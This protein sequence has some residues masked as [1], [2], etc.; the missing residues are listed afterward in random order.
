MITFTD[1]YKRYT[2]QYEALSGLSFELSKGEMAFL[3]GHSG[4]GKSTL[5]KLIALIERAS[6]G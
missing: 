4:A 6:H 3:T 1:V 5:L 2:N